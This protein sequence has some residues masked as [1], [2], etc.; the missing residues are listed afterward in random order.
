MVNLTEMSSGTWADEF[1]VTNPAPTLTGTG[2]TPT[3]GYNNNTMLE[4]TVT[5]MGFMQG[6]KV[7][8][9]R[10]TFANIS[11]EVDTYLATA[12]SG[13][14]DLSAAANGTWYVNVT[15]PDEQGTV[16]VKTFTINWPLPTINVTGGFVPSEGVNNGPQSMT[17]NGN[18]FRPDSI[19]YLNKTGYLISP[20][21]MP[22]PS[23]NQMIPQFN[24]NGVP[25]GAWNV[26]VK[27]SDDHT[28]T[29]TDKFWIFYP[30]SPYVENITPPTGINTSSIP[31]V[32]IGGSG[33]QPGATVNLTHLGTNIQ[34][35]PVVVN[36][37]SYITCTL[38]ITGA[39]TGAWDVIVT[40]NDNHSSNN[41]KKFTITA[42]PAPTASFT[43]TSTP[44]P[45]PLNV[46]FNDTSINDP[47]AWN[48]SF[49]DGT[50][51]FNTTNPSL[52][53]CT[54]MYAVGTWSAQLTVSNAYGSSTSAVQ[55]ITV[56]PPPTADFTYTPENGVPP[57]HVFFSDTSM[58]G[59]SSRLWR[60]GID[61]YTSTN[62]T[63]DFTYYYPGMY[64]V[65]LTVTNTTGTN[66]TEKIV[67]V[68]SA[69]VLPVT[70]FTGSPR[71]GTTTSLSVQF[72]D[73]SIGT[74][75]TGY[76]WIFSD[77]PGTIYLTQNLTRSFSPGV[78]NVNHSATN[79]AGTIWKNE[80]GYI[81]VTAPVD[82]PVASFTPNQTTGSAPLTV[83]FTDTSTNNPTSWNWS[84]GDT[85]WYN[86]TISSQRNATHSYAA[87]G[88]YTAQLIV[89][90][91][92]G[93]NTTV[94]GTTISV[95]P[96]PPAPPIASF[97]PNQT[98]GS[99]PLTVLFTDTSTNNPTSWNW[100][101][102]DTT[103]YNTTIS[104][105]RNATHSYAAPGS[106]T[107]Q[108]IVA[109]AGGSNTTVPGTT[110]S[111]TPAPPSANFTAS[112]TAGFKPLYVQFT[113]TSATGITNWL[114]KFGIDQYSAGAQNPDFTYNQI[115]NYTVN[116]T[117]TNASGITTLSKPN[118]IVVTNQ[119]VANFTA[120]QTNGPVPL[121]VQFTD[122][123]LYATS[124]YWEFGDGTNSTD[125]SPSHLYTAVGVRDVRLKVFNAGG[126]GIPK[127]ITITS[128]NP[129]PVANFTVNKTIGDIPL[130]VQ[131][132]DQSTGTITTRNWDFGDGG[133]SVEPNPVHTYLTPNVYTVRLEVLNSDC[134]NISTKQ[135]LIN[136]TQPKPVAAFGGFPA[137]GTV[138]ETVF[139][140]IDQS[141]NNPTSWLWNFGDGTYNTTQNPTHIYQL[142]GNYII[143]LT[144]SNAG[145]SD[146]RTGAA[147]LVVKNPRAIANFTGTPTL[148]SIPL[149]VQF[150]DTSSNFPDTSA[151]DFGDN[152]FARDIRNPVHTYN[153][154]GTY[155]VTL[156]VNDTT[157]G[158]PASTL[159]RPAYITVVKTPIA[160]FDA[161]PKSG[162][163][164]LFVRFTDH[165]QGNP[166]RFSWKFG[167]GTVSTARNP[168]H[169]YQR[170]GV[171]TV[172]ETVQNLA[173]FNTTVKQNL[174]TVTDL[175]QAGFIVN[176][177]SGIAP[178]TIQFTDISTG[179]P[180]VSSWN[181]DFGD[182]SSHSVQQNPVHTYPPGVYSVQLIVS[183]GIKSNTVTKSSLIT[184]GT[185]TGADF[186]MKPVEG[187]DVPLMIQFTDNSAGNP[188]LIYKWQF[189]DGYVSKDPN[190]V[191]TYMK[192]GN[193][194]VT[195]TITANNGALSTVSKELILTGTPV[196][197]FKATPTAGS[198]P[199]TVQFTDTS[200]NAPTKWFWTFG[201]GTY[202]NERNPVHTYNSPD[203]FTVKLFV[204]N[205]YGNDE[206]P[207]Y[208][209]WIDVSP[210][211]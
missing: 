201:D 57:L 199:L 49:G 111:V 176:A 112:P 98:T 59:I 188:I 194:T 66:S 106:Y 101:F 181:W 42:P 203:K 31:N 132:T 9:T 61:E 155:T 76:Q 94:P 202:G 207:L 128:R 67:I 38:P 139:H 193:Y 163:V 62:K 209:D 63:P 118:Y 143:I 182:G 147:P 171:Y 116:L 170:P 198:V 25:V 113:D 10:P 33:F 41:D 175:P 28:A 154:A 129:C 173:G 16:E 88:S 157:A 35:N 191:H 70:N 187:G 151:W 136:A 12:I 126:E 169:N 72:N 79:S 115:G 44:G 102:G 29:A 142:K 134:S 74:G 78:Y 36:N 200:S 69:P 195:L 140:F 206:T 93:S 96:A 100:S 141:T 204:S 86:T 162:T 177:T 179:T 103:W 189:G 56:S 180:P 156:A 153:Q 1:E 17:I 40:N 75:I 104:S 3:S 184:I 122:S 15:N 43:N 18:N 55:T 89:A 22:P 83:L 24:L 117:V 145:G 14:F 26:E 148:G 87:P 160:Q 52:R 196:A 82:P 114:W 39:I 197:S 121:N 77:S 60:F 23:S 174:I 131:F 21:S 37:Q 64:T 183:N 71:S 84:F 158:Q 161:D 144:A 11:A 192:P 6:A 150:T 54:H 168:T 127:N 120:N 108:L 80:T 109:N 95:T 34:A 130:K 68:T 133:T 58:T 119:P 178:T 53:N 7:N 123:S 211:P 135:N 20:I 186:K 146:T 167:D 97:T 19:A 208:K 4:F 172:T 99:A 149:T 32:L 205:I 90:N 138:N 124:W 73:T 159:T 185:P 30:A 45:A 51:W 50:P 92:G 65:K 91:A 2:I 27:N 210:F 137:T 81:T 125:Q 48:W 13:T 152:T 105:Q 164:P 190:P 107:A 46:Q 8:L 110:I 5:G 165:S 47:T 85:T 166:I